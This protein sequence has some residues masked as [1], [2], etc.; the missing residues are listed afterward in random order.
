MLCS[1][2][3]SL[4]SDQENQFALLTK[5]DSEDETIILPCS[6]ITDFDNFNKL[7]KSNE[8]YQKRIV[9]KLTPLV[10]PS[11][12]MIKST[13]SMMRL[14][15]SRDVALLY[16]LKNLMKKKIFI[17]TQF[18]KVIKGVLVKKFSKSNDESLPNKLIDESISSVL[19][20]CGDWDC[21]RLER[22]KKMDLKKL[23]EVPDDSNANKTDQ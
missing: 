12:A 11:Q 1:A 2:A 16:N 19:N 8:N 18:H 3:I 6:E 15:M 23:Q 10:Y 22:K 7:L 20:H 9:R 4:D 17:D 13:V 14:A 5:V 21:G